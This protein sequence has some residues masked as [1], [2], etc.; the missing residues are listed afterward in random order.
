MMTM[1]N[2]IT[3]ALLYN[4]GMSEAMTIKFRIETILDTNGV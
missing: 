4:Y 3:C 2:R 1:G